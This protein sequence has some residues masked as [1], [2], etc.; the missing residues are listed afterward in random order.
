M[1]TSLDED[2]KGIVRPELPRAADGWTELASVHGS[3]PHDLQSRSPPNP[4]AVGCSCCA[5]RLSR[6][7]PLVVVARHFCVHLLGEHI[8]E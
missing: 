7:I 6:P 3:G 5:N 2:L 1:Y 8:K 4:V